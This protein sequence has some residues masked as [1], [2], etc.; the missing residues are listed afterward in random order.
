MDVKLVWITPD[1]DNRI[2]WMA[3]VSNPNAVES[4]PSEKLIAY[5]LKHK[6]YSPFEMANL[7]VEI[8]TTRDI[9]RQIL[10]HRSFHFQEFSQR[11]AVVAEE[12]KYSEVRL[13]DTKNRQNSIVTDDLFLTK[14]WA[15]I[16]NQVWDY[17]W[18]FYQ[19]ALKLG[20][21]KELAR[22]L[23]PEGLTRTRMFMNG[24]IRDWLHYIST[25]T[26]PETQYEHRVIAKEIQGLLELSC[27]IVSKAARQAG[28]YPSP[29]TDR[30]DESGDGGKI[31]VV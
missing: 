29:D 4:D 10:R 20:V 22:K 25:R 13:Q 16:Q 15:D 26:G 6:H 19:A 17:C 23:L 24:T 31:E 8:N 21:A 27:P 14:R 9:A 30:R 28:L 1:T 2:A 5:L 18:F 3:R 12:P 11:Y 7:C